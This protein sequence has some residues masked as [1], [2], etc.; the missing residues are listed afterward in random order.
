MSQCSQSLPL[1]CKC[2]T[3]RSAIALTTGQILDDAAHEATPSTQVLV[4]L[5]GWD[6][7]LD[8]RDGGTE[9]YEQDREKVDRRHEEN[10]VA[11]GV[12]EVD[13]GLPVAHLGASPC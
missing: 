11:Q 4:W 10:R 7:Q 1:A 2:K 8:K 6:E 9:D 5:R 12:D 13:Q 3:E